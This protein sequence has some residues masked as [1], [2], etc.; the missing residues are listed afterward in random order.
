MSV[1]NGRIVHNKS[2]ELMAWRK[3]IA[4]AAKSAGAELTDAPIRLKLK[5]RLVKPKT[6]KRALPTVPP[7]LDKLI[8]ACLDSLTD[9]AYKDDSQVIDISAEKIY[10]D[11]PGLDLE[12]YWLNASIFD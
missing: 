12:I 11:T 2:K 4:I 3:A 6:V 8:R 5:F 7:D 10:S 9:V 1:F